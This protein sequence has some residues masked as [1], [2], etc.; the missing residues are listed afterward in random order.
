MTKSQSKQEYDK[1]ESESERERNRETKT[2]RFAIIDRQKIC[3][4][5]HWRIKTEN[6]EDFSFQP[7]FF[8][9]SIILRQN[10][11]HEFPKN[12]TR[13]LLD[14]KDVAIELHTKD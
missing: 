13:V 5:R 2:K 14:A 12:A 10:K 4:H 8:F 3:H 9:K 11:T 7:F 6:K 1:R